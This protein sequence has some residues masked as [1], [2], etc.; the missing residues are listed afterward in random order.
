[1]KL[2]LIL[3]LFSLYSLPVLA[4]HSFG[5]EFGSTSTTIKGTSKTDSTKGLLVSNGNTN[6]KLLYTWSMS[7]NFHLKFNYG[8]KSYGFIDEDGV[9]N[10][11]TEFSG[12]VYDLGVKL[13]FA[14]WGALSLLQVNDFDASYDETDTMQ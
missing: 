8:Q 9:I 5:L 11:G 2:Y 12:S 4:G 1:M 6:Y 10:N 14:S 13:I 3:L 7:K